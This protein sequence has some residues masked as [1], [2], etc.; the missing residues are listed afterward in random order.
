MA[1]IHPSPPPLDLDELLSR[2][3]G[4]IDLLDKLLLNFDDYLGPQVSE[5]EL[6]IQMKNV[7]QVRS[8]AHRIKG[9]ALT[10]SAKPLSQSAERLESSAM[11]SAERSADCLDEVLRECERLSA[12]VRVRIPK[13]AACVSA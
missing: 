3:M 7:E 2:C 10:V 5:L 9:A 4:R 12:A 1:D 8:I 11:T 13:E 6:A